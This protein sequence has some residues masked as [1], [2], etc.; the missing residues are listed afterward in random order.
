MNQAKKAVDGFPV[1]GKASAQYTRTS[2]QGDDAALADAT[3]LGKTGESVRVM[4][5]VIR[6]ED[7]RM[8]ELRVDMP[9]GTPD[10]KS[11]TAVFKDSRKRLKIL[12]T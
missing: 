10:E 6:T 11:G 5:L 12:P 4:R 1:D 9:K 7:D 2:F 8:Y 3:L